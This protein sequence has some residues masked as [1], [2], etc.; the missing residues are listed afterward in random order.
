[1]RSS[2][3]LAKHSDD[4]GIIAD[5]MNDYL[6]SQGITAK[7][8]LKNQCLGILLESDTAP[9]QDEMM[10]FVRTSLNEL[11]WKFIRKVKV[12]GRQIGERL[13]AWQQ[14]F[15][16][17]TPEELPPR[18]VQVAVET[19][20]DDSSSIS[21][22]LNQGQ[23]IVQLEMIEEAIPGDSLDAEKFLRFQFSPEITA[24]LPLASVKEM[25]RISV[26]EILPVPDLPNCVLGVHNCRG[27]M[28]WLVDLDIQIGL[29]SLGLDSRLLA[30]PTSNVLTQQRV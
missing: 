6:N 18:Q 21:D 5:W 26:E 20:A 29:S 28:L 8:V 13:P 19:V 25:L 16:V 7:A 11:N 15:K 22:W 10:A 12:Y 14:K 17:G 4:P 23:T 30:L 3:Q 27:E 24:L 2:S 9:S 1:M